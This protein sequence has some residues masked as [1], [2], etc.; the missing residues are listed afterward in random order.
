MGYGQNVGG[1]SIRCQDDRIFLKYCPD[2]RIQF[3][4]TIARDTSARPSEILNLRGREINFK[5]AKDKTY[6]VIYVNGKTGPR[7]VPLISSIP[8]VK[9]CFYISAILIIFI[10]TI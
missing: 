7:T 10:A 2:K 8:Y 4:H 3:Y 5:L 9:G 1:S 6:A